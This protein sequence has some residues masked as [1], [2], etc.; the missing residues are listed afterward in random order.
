LILASKD[1]NNVVGVR[2][3]Q[4]PAPH[5]NGNLGYWCSEGQKW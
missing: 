3:L 1:G 2:G 5:M 4:R